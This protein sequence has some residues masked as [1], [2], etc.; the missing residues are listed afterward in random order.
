MNKLKE[1]AAQ[2]YWSILAA[3]LPITFT[4]RLICD[5]AGWKAAVELCDRHA[6]SIVEIERKWT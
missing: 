1:I 4:V 3:L 6:D 2:F 5:L